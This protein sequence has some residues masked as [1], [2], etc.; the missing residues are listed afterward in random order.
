VVWSRL[1]VLAYAQPASDHVILRG[2]PD[3]TARANRG[4]HHG[5]DDTVRSSPASG[6]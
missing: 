1:E 6:W 2:V 4:G 3:M 5:C